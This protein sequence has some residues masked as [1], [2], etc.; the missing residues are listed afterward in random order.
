M[1]CRM[2]VVMSAVALLSMAPVYAQSI[3]IRPAPP[4]PVVEVVP[5][6][7]VSGYYIWQPGYWSWSGLRYVWVAGVYVRPSRPRAA[8]VPGHWVARRP[9]WVWVGGHWR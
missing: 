8:W 7:P 9:G 1:R 6:R 5:A 2:V 4:A 3:V